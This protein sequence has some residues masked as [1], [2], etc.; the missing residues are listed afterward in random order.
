MV[1]SLDPAR[2]V[3]NSPGAAN[4]LGSEQENRVLDFLSPHTVR[5][6]EFW[7]AAPDQ[8]RKLLADYR[9]PVVDDE[10]ARCGTQSFGGNGE[11]RIEQHLEQLAAVRKFGGYH[12]YHHDMFQLGYGDSSIPP[13]GIPDPEFSKFHLK[14]F[15]YL[16]SIAPREVTAGAR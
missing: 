2:L 14:A 10:P 3:T 4:V 16:R 12:V 7:T 1:K 6:G 11:T 9:K 8:I 13:N 15:E 5:K